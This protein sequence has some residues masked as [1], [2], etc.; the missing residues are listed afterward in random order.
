MP[1]PQT[2]DTTSDSRSSSMPA[3]IVVKT[4][5]FTSLV[6]S[7]CSNPDASQQQLPTPTDKP[8]QPLVTPL[9]LSAVPPTLVPTIETTAP[10]YEVVQGM[11]VVLSNLS[12][13][14]E[15]RRLLDST[16]QSSPVL[17]TMCQN[18]LETIA[19]S[20][21]PDIYSESV[22]KTQQTVDPS[23]TTNIVLKTNDTM[24]EFVRLYKE[25]RADTKP[26]TTSIV[27]EMPDEQFASLWR[28]YALINELTA[29]C[30][31]GRM[32]FNLHEFDN[33]GELPG[34]ENF[35]PH[36]LY[37]IRT[38]GTN[39]IL[40]K[41]GKPYYSEFNNV[42]TEALGDITSIEVFL[43]APGLTPQ[44]REQ[45]GAVVDEIADIYYPVHYHFLQTLGQFDANFIATIQELSHKGDYLGIL[46]HIEDTT[47]EWLANNPSLTEQQRAQ[48][49]H[50]IT[51]KFYLGELEAESV[52]ASLYQAL[53]AAGIDPMVFLNQRPSSYIQ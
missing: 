20:D 28:Q 11:K 42:V 2:P 51:Q 4:L 33:Y 3:A 10:S 37:E 14:D 25:F 44:E 43:N 40:S 17:A 36:S 13:P 19:F 26:I 47:F 23:T 53:T 27:L 50:D 38:V 49:A 29:A 7:G 5:L 24:I 6:F 15:M 30:S 1:V 32:T 31:A 41:D 45:R 52:G 8:D 34:S 22:G 46:N 12:N 16:L 48:L 9:P 21:D 18:T 39:I 35:D